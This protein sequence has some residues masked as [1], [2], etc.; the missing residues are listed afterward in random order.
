[1]TNF[2]K[3]VRKALIDKGLKQKDIAEEFGISRPYLNDIIT[4]KEKGGRYR[5]LLIEKLFRGK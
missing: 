1:M 4:E 5:E 2:E 3:K